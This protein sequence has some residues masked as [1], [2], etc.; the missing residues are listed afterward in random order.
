MDR[1]RNELLYMVEE[2]RTEM[3]TIKWSK[4][5]WNG[6]ILSRNCLLKMLLKKREKRK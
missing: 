1:W 4:A 5:D 3:N 6:N 2:N